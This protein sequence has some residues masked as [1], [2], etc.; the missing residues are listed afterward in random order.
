MI[1]LVRKLQGEPI[2]YIEKCKRISARNSW[3][4]RNQ[5]KRNCK[6]AINE[7]ARNGEY[8][9]RLGDLMDATVEWLKQEG[10]HLYTKFNRKGNYDAWYARW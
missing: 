4:L 8:E 10:F 6:Y 3:I 1:S 2:S 5:E 7:A 9:C